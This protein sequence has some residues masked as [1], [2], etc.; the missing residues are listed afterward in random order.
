MKEAHD[1]PV[2]GKRLALMVLDSQRC[3]LSW[4]LR[5]ENRS[6]SI[7][8]RLTAYSLDGKQVIYPTMI[9]DHD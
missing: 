1:S 3:I 5:G 8:W 2:S 9:A 4:T 6:L 7:A